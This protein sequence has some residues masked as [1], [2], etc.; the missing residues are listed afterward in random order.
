LFNQDIK[1]AI[2]V[3]LSVSRV[4][5]AAQTDIMRQISGQLKLSLAQYEEVAHFARFGAELDLATRRQITRGQ[6]L[7]EVLRQPAYS[8]ISLAH[9]VLI[10]YAAGRGFLDDLPVDQIAQ[11]EAALWDYVQQEHRS[12]TRQIESDRALDEE[13]EASL[14]RLIPEFNA[15]FS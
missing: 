5:G 14:D 11:Y 15:R 8:P 2:D 1:P 6:R 9:Q 13:L 7:R 12:I 3:G 4:G 10:L